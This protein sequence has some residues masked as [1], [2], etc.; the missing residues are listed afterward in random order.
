[1]SALTERVC[2][3]CGEA[4]IGKRSDAI[5]CSRLCKN[6]APKYREYQRRW[7]KENAERRKAY[8]Q[9]WYLANRDEVNERA[10]K[11]AQANPEKVREIQRAWRERNPEQHR[12]AVKRARLANRDGFNETRNR[13]M[14][15]P[16]GRAERIEASQRRRARMLGNGYEVISAAA[17]DAKLAEYEGRCAY[18]GDAATQRDHVIPLVRGG[19]HTLDNLVPACG[20]CNRSKGDKLLNEWEVV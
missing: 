14:R 7:I 1:M 16:K 3:Q 6:R 19:S 5:Y 12:A 9:S 20:P 11:W 15:T 18:C 8:E 17:W 10:R 2:A 4:L 13:R